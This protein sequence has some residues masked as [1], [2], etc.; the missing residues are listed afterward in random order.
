MLP[1]RPSLASLPFHLNRHIA[2]NFLLLICMAVLVQ[3]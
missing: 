3:S 2:C 1:L